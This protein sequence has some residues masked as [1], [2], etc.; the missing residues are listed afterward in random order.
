MDGG[1]K[2]GFLTELEKV[3]EVQS[4]THLDNMVN[5]KVADSEVGEE[6]VPE[7]MFSVQSELNKDKQRTSKVVS[8]LLSFSVLHITLGLLVMILNV[9]FIYDG[10]NSGWY[11]FIDSLGTE[12]KVISIGE[13]IMTGIFFIII[14]CFVILILCKHMC[15]NT[16]LYP[17]Y[18]VIIFLSFSLIITTACQIGMIHQYV[19]R[20]Q[21]EKMEMLMKEEAR[22]TTVIAIQTV[23][24]FMVFISSLTAVLLLPSLQ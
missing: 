13:G 21:E 6:K 15:T 3:I 12:L 23:A 9:I 7:K 14:A 11:Y 24:Y 19:P 16:S 8:V 20:D 22:Q 4:S 10:M 18:I 2:N 5:N 17:L 1:D